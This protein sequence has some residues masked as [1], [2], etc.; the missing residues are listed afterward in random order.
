M[1]ELHTGRQEIKRRTSRN[2]SILA[3]ITEHFEGKLWF[4]DLSPVEP[5]KGFV[6]K[7]NLSKSYR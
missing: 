7:I 3:S 5:K 1:Q 6:L 2:L 4:E